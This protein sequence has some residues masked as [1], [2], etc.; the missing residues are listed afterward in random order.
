[1]SQQASATVAPPLSQ[2]ARI[3]VAESSDV[4]RESLARFLQERYETFTA[5][6]SDELISV[7]ARIGRVK[8]VLCDTELKPLGGLACVRKARALCPAAEFALMTRQRVEP[9]MPDLKRH[10]LHNVLV[11]ATPFNFR[12]F[13]VY[14]ANLLSPQ[15]AFGLRRY[16]N[17]PAE[18]HHLEI[19]TQTDRENA[20]RQISDFFAR[21]RPY[22]SDVSEIRL[23]CEELLN[24]AIYHA[25]RH[26]SGLEKYPVGTF[27]SLEPGEQVRVSYGLDR[28]NLGCAVSD[29]QGALTVEKVMSRFDRQITLEGLLDESG[30]GLHLTRNLSDQM[31]VNI[32]PGVQTEIILLFSHRSA[33]PARPLLVNVVTPVPVT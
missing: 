16:L 9:M 10:R 26:P 28:D 14:V 23:G 30:R 29:N 25:F 19:R 18:I 8:L 21:Y 5:A 11:K 27:R 31:I 7:L 13:G 20:L 32:H 22:E 24:N 12:E 2:P 4:L 3:V 1:L 6:T 17:D 15:S 33:P